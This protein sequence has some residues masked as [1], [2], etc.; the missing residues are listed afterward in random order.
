MTPEGR[1]KA[2]ITNYLNTLQ[3]PNSGV[4]C[5][6]RMPVPTGYGKPGLD[7]EGCINGRFFAIEAKAPGEWLTPRQRRTTIEILSGGGA[8]FCVS[9]SA[10]VQSFKRWV[11]RCPALDAATA[12]SLSLL[13][14]ARTLS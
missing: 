12:A 4:V 6:Y 2:V 11:E 8:V 14:A 3:R 5:Y 13:S 7:Y 1:V 10:G 9:S